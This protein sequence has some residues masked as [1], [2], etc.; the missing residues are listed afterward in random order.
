MNKRQYQWAQIITRHTRL[1]R[2]PSFR[3][4]RDDGRAKQRP[5]APLRE[6]PGCTH[7]A[8]NNRWTWYCYPG[9]YTV[10]LTEYLLTLV[11]ARKI[12]DVLEAYVVVPAGQRYWL[13]WKWIFFDALFFLALPFFRIPRL[14]FS[15]RVA[16]AQLFIM[17]CANYAALG[18]WHVS[19]SSFCPPSS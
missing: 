5:A 7:S 10:I 2:D 15:M 19:S 4:S 14:N 8:P 13:L 3:L 9:V 17:V 6:L 12:W 1:T 18:D 16:L 11:Q